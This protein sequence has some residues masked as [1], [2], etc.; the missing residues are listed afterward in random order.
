MADMVTVDPAFWRGRKVFVT[1]DTGFKGAWL[2]SW[3]VEMGADVSGFALPPKDESSLFSQIGMGGRVKHTHGDIRVAEAI[4]QAMQA[5]AP[6]IVIHLAAQAIVRL[7]YA[8]PKATF[9][10][11]VAGAVNLLEA[12]RHT[13]SVRACV[14]ITSDKCYRNREWPWGY[15][16]TDE[17]GGS[18]PYSASKAA[19]ELIVASYREALFSD[20][21]SFSIATARAGNVIG[22]GDWSPDRIV[23][24]TIRAL[25]A[26]KPIE[27]RNPDATRPWQH[28]LEPLSGYLLLAQRLCSEPHR[29]EGAWNFGP[30][31]DAAMT[32]GD[33]VS[34]IIDQWGS[35]KAVFRRDNGPQEQRLLQLSI[36]K[37]RND[38]GWG[39]R[40]HTHRA[41]AETVRWY[42][43]VKE[44]QNPAAVTNGQIA[45]YMQGS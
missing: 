23:P 8:E 14:F 26:D 11:N 3:L 1:G 35:G 32:V 40:W 5:C 12:I 37:A 6:Q 10:T 27:I 9:D 38:L 44:G 18:D 19:A 17:L 31:P 16:E 29:H 33:L 25:S 39:P 24:D 15:R 7:S 21:D 41:L 4:Q 30:I 36:D 28:V 42:K 22:G 13:P 34:T 20:R 43:N 2:C 45:A